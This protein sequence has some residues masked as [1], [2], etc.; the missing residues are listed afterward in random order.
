MCRTF[1]NYGHDTALCSYKNMKVICIMQERN[2]PTIHVDINTSALSV[3]HGAEV[4]G[5]TLAALLDEMKSQ[6]K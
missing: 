1:C 4:K 6:I 2:N 5:S 3:A